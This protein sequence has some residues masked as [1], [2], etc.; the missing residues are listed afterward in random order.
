MANYTASIC[1]TD[2]PRQFIREG[3]NG[4]KYLNI[5]IGER[6]QPSQY[7]DTHFIKVSIPREQQQEGEDYFIGD[8]KELAARTQQSAPKAAPAAAPIPPQDD[9][10]DLPY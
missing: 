7:G 3:R 8:A 2:I 10:D 1:L 6:K 5:Y 9:N 4:K